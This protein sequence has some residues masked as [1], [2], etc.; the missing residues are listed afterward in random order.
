M[1][2]GRKIREMKTNDFCVSGKEEA[3]TEA[4]L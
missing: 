1:A 4:T 2:C 3:K